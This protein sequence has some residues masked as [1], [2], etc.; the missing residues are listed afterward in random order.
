MSLRSY[1]GGGGGGYQRQLWLNPY[2]TPKDQNGWNTLTFNTAF[3]N[4]CSL[5]SNFTVPPPGDYVE[6][7]VLLEAG[8]WALS[9]VGERNTSLGIATVTLD[10]VSVGQVDFYGV[11]DGGFRFAELGGIVVANSGIKTL[12]LQ[13][14]SKNGA[15]T[16]YGA[17][18]Q[19]IGLRRTGP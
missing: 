7:D 2:S 19:V 4:N 15:S 1:L 6:W 13:M 9:I 5:Q 18:L 12:R 11:F 16:N 10:G 8:T 14:A 3:V 17:Y